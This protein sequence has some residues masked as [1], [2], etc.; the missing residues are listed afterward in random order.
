M[1]FFPGVPAH[2][3]DLRVN[4]AIKFNGQSVF[5]AVEIQDAIFNAE[6]TAKL[7]AQPTVPQESPC[8][9]FGLRWGPSKFAN[10][11]RG[12]FHGTII[13]AHKSPPASTY[14]RNRLFTC[15]RFCWIFVQTLR[16]CE[17]RRGPQKR[18]SALLA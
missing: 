15:Q 1:I 7:R 13:S 14:R 12:D 10:S 16:Q 18:R 9:L 6:L 4:A 17:E 3:V 5:K 2:L 11:R 8:G